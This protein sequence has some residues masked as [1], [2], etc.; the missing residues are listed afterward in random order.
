MNT[1]TP[2]NLPSVGE[3]PDAITGYV[4]EVR[5]RY[6]GESKDG[7]PYSVQSLRLKG[8]RR[9][10][11]VKFWNKD[12]L[13][14]FYK[15]TIKVEGDLKVIEEENRRTKKTYTVV[16]AGDLSVI[17]EGGSDA[18]GSSGQSQGKS[19]DKYWVT[20]GQCEPY[21]A[22]ADQVRAALRENPNLNILRIGDNADEWKDA[23]HYGLN[24]APPP[25]PPAKKEET[26][27]G[28]PAVP[29][30]R[31]AHTEKATPPP[32][33]KTVTVRY[34]ETRV[35]KQ[36]ETCNMQVELEV[37]PDEA[38]KAYAYAKSVVRSGIV[39]SIDNWHIDR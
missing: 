29:G 16:N 37:T 28:P 34:T 11:T 10:V 27:S 26:R 3:K 39:L 17:S 22:T 6:A 32:S 8:Q 21:E 5:D 1:I 15:K 30:S 14:G 36:Y 23:K 24:V 4:E 20:D 13:T 25:P 2:D 7:K 19:A 38:G 35:A 18:S 9:G 33:A 31:Q 12:D